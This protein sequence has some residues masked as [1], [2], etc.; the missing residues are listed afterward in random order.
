MPQT[1]A[2]V[3]DFVCH[4]KRRSCFSVELWKKKNLTRKK[5]E[6]DCFSWKCFWWAQTDCYGKQHSSETFTVW[7]ERQRQKESEEIERQGKIN[8]MRLWVWQWCA[9]VQQQPWQHL[10][11]DLPHFLS[12]AVMYGAL[13]LRALAFCCDLMCITQFYAAFL[14][15]SRAIPPPFAIAC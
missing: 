9:T 14:R 10:F 5:E 7:S 1:L 8:C 2:G 3:K 12:Q 15:Y 4:Y 6:R 11:R 13:T